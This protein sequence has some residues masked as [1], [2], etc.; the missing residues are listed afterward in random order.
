MENIK[1]E[2]RDLIKSYII[3]PLI[4]VLSLTVGIFFIAQDG[5]IEGL[6]PLII[7]FYF[8]V[9][10]IYNAI[11]VFDLFYNK[12]RSKKGKIFITIFSILAFISSG[13]F[14]AFYLIAK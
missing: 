14:I 5:F 11:A 6:N 3:L 4:F 7:W 13:L 2:K 8:A 1:E 10:I 9:T 12:E